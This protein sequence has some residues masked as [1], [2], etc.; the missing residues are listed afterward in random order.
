MIISFNSGKSGWCEYVLNG[1]SK[2]QRNQ[3]LIEI[4]DGDFNLT[5]KIYTAT[6]AKQSYT[7]IVMAF[8]GKMSNEKMKEI[9]EEFIADF[10]VGYKEDEV[11]RAAIIHQDTENSH[12]HICLPKRN[13]RT[14]TINDYYY[15]KVDRK[16][17][18]LIKQ[19]LILKHR[20]EV[21]TK[22]NIEHETENKELARIELWRKL[23]GQKQITLKR[24]RGR[25]KTKKELGEYIKSCYINDLISNFEEMK[26]VL[27]E[28]DGIEVD[29][30]GVDMEGRDF[31]TIK[32]NRNNKIRLRGTIY[33]Q[34]YTTTAKSKENGNDGGITSIQ[35]ENSRDDERIP[36]ELGENDEKQLKR[37]CEKLATA[38]QAR[39]KKI[40]K[41]LARAR[42]KAVEENNPYR[43]L[44]DHSIFSWSSYKPT[45]STHFANYNTLHPQNW[46]ILQARHD[47]SNS[48][49]EPKEQQYILS[50]KEMT[51]E[52]SITRE[53]ANITE[54]IEKRENKARERK[55]GIARAVERIR[56]G[57]ETVKSRLG[58]IKQM[59]ITETEQ[60]K[61][62]NL[63][64]FICGHGGII[65]KKKS[66]KSTAVI[67]YL[68]T[69]LIVSKRQENNHY[70]FFNIADGCGGTI[71]DFY[72]NFIRKSVTEPF[73]R[74]LQYIRNI[75]NGGEIHKLNYDLQSND[76]DSIEKVQQFQKCLTMMKEL[77]NHNSYLKSRYI[78]EETQ[79]KFKDTMKLDY[80]G[81]L[82]FINQT[83][84]NGRFIPC[85]AINQEKKI[86]IGKK[87]IS[88]TIIA[89]NINIA[90]KNL[91]LFE[92]NIDAMS[93]YQMYKKTGTYISLGGNVSEKQ[94]TDLEELIKMQK[95]TQINF[96]F[97]NDA[98]GNRIRERI[99]R[100]FSP[101]GTAKSSVLTPKSKDWNQ[102][103]QELEQEKQRER[104]EEQQEHVRERKQ[105]GERGMEW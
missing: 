14:N 43:L 63:I 53:V 74:S 31:I 75:Y 45:Q 5:K 76:A 60:F 10:L 59:R 73:W 70:I 92:S 47:D 57:I 15:D 34:H 33:G 105:L 84:E 18:N 52:Q 102:D 26:Q 32:D 13:L 65:D 61:Q 104:E 16:R 2:K 48:G 24:A 50:E 28:F 98:G 22:Q 97:D 78:N 6:R 71:F 36:R 82:C 27:N 64:D 56:R 67:N 86:N 58:G 39:V 68:N 77:T 89:D 23:H 83:I 55:Q 100:H 80:Q 99:E 95:V 11:N 87:G 91:Y 85:G 88:G 9:Y 8:K 44:C 54:E 90:S 94:L 93:F 81:N 4:I 46:D 12:I 41:K 3:E 21:P 37:I 62:N 1:T 19:K 30:Y 25:E 49:K 96:C 17:I 35:S 51:H 29:K 40:S 66:C 79:N 42:K 69:K 101:Y 103:L 72:D 7:T 38:N 20:L